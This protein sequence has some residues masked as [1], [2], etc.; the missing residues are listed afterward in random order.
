MDFGGVLASSRKKLIKTLKGN[1]GPPTT[2]RR[3]EPDVR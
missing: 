3:E 1:P 2:L